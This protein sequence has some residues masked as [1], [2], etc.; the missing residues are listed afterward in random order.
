MRIESGRLG[1]SAE[2]ALG[3]RPEPLHVSALRASI[4]AAF[5]PPAVINASP[6][7]PAALRAPLALRTPASHAC[8]A[9]CGL[10][11]QVSAAPFGN[12]GGHGAGEARPR[13]VVGKH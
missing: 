9:A 6:C 7:L 5:A 11:V 13:A 3:P 2:W 10:A 4:P 8:C 1:A 12:G